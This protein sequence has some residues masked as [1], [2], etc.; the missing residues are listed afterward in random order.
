MCYKKNSVA[1]SI[2]SRIFPSFWT[3]LEL[4]WGL[5]LKCMKRVWF[6][7][8]LICFFPG[9][10]WQYGVHPKLQIFF[11]ISLTILRFWQFYLFQSEESW[12]TEKFIAKIRQSCRDI[13]IQKMALE[14]TI[15]QHN[16]KE[17]CILR[18]VCAQIDSNFTKTLCEGKIPLSTSPLNHEQP[19]WFR[20]KTEKNMSS[21]FF[22]VALWRDF[23]DSPWCD[24]VKSW[25]WDSSLF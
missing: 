21:L 9:M 2:L 3:S 25:I 14:N 22:A 23:M 5:L 10:K 18:A 17:Y 16:H 19:K 11:Q 7:R 6:E 4:K 24:S 1:S 13:L 20:P 15:S 12:T 8:H